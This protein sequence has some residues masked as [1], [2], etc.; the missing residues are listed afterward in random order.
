MQGYACTMHARIGN[1]AQ[2]RASTSSNRPGGGDAR[3]Q[4]EVATCAEPRSHG[5][6]FAALP[7]SPTSPHTSK[8]WDNIG[9]SLDSEPDSM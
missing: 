5:R 7:T 4:S 6:P 3:T 9:V 8:T 2:L 1:E